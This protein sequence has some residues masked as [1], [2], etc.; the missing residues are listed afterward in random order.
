MTRDEPQ[1][2]VFFINTCDSC[3]IFLLRDHSDTTTFDSEKPTSPT[4]FF[5]ASTSVSSRPSSLLREHLVAIRIHQPL[6]LTLLR[7]LNLGQPPIRLGALVDRPRL[8]FEHA[9]R[10]YDLA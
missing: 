3:V 7:D 2:T 8:L 9:V 6:Q 4:S 5:S 1:L 10:F